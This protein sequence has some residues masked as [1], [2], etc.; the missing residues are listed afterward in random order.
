MGNN[1]EQLKAYPNWNP[2]EQIILERVV[3]K[4]HLVDNS[5]QSN[6]VG[7]KILNN[8]FSYFQFTCHKYLL[9]TMD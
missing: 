6:N 4:F 5:E 9:S 3:S 8:I 7:S 2:T 1:I